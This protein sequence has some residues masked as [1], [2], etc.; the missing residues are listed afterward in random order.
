MTNSYIRSFELDRKFKN[1]DPKSISKD[2]EYAKYKEDEQ[3]TIKMSA[4]LRSLTNKD[5]RHRGVQHL[6]TDDRTPGNHATAQA[7]SRNSSG[8]FVIKKQAILKTK[9]CPGATTSANVVSG[10]ASALNDDLIERRSQ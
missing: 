10:T 6:R 9:V 2:P 7:L 5:R 4:I 3:N 8:S 1:T